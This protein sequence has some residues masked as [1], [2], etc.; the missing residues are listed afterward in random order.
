LALVLSKTEVVWRHLLVMA[1]EEDRRRTSLTR[2]SQQLGLPPSTIHKALVRPR[3]I[4]AVRGTSL[5]LRVLDPKRLLLLWAARRDLAGDV[6]YQTHVAAGVNQI[7]ERLPESAIPTAYS[8]FVARRR[9]NTVAGYDQVV[10]YGPRADVEPV[11]P[12]RRGRPNLLV[13]EPDPFLA[14]YGRS[15][16]TPQVY[17]DLFNLP[18]WQAQLF[19]DALNRQLFLSDITMGRR[20]GLPLDLLSVQGAHV[21]GA[22]APAPEVQ[23]V[24]RMAALLDR[25]DSLPGETDRREIWRLATLPDGLD[26]DQVARILSASSHTPDEQ[27]ALVDETFHL[28]EET[29]TLRRRDLSRLRKLKAEALDSVRSLRKPVTRSRVR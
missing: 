7:E 27:V 14:G 20:L 9:P 21:S 18:T 28:L 29:D 12:P 16:P 2:L 1:L 3:Q 19:L 25:P 8:A 26:F 11:F 23:M 5:G 17:A 13:L 15:A 6:T 10:V 24:A 4:G 22:E